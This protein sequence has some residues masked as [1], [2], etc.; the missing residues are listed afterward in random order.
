MTG[1]FPHS[2]FYGLSSYAT[3]NSQVGTPFGGFQDFEIQADEGSV[4][5][6]LDGADRTSENRTFTLTLSGQV[7]PGEGERAPNTFYV[8]RWAR[9][10]RIRR[11]TCGSASTA[12]TAPMRA[13][14]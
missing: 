11:S 1:E 4:N 14:T 5:P 3:V 6:F 12:S 10:T 7:D 13:W 9:P 2:R 8:G